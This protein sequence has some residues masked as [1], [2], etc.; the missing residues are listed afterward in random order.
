[1]GISRKRP[2]STPLLVGIG[3]SA[4]LLLGLIT[5]ELLL[6][7]FVLLQEPGPVHILRDLRLAVLHCLLAGYLPAAFLYLLRSA[8]ANLIRLKPLL[9]SSDDVLTI[10]LI[11]IAGCIGF[12]LLGA[13]VTVLTPYLSALSPWNPRI[14]PPEVVWH[15]VL[16][17]IIGWFAGCLSYAIVKVSIRISRTAD[18]LQSIDLLDLSPLAPFVRQGVRNVL[19]IVGAMSILS[20]FLMESGMLLTV[21]IVEGIVIPIAVIGLILPVRG[22]HRRIHDA[23]QAELTWA[24]DGIHE[25]QMRLKDSSAGTVSSQMADLITYYQFI[26]EVPEW[27]FRIS[28]F[29]RFVLYLLIPL[30]SWGGGLL[31][32]L[33]LKRLLV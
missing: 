7:R 17:P 3:L 6:G 11:S 8:K 26:E 1:M 10:P 4:V 27:P 33:L 24:L 25:A 13:A 18:L 21:M 28:T 15:R 29:V 20:F 32:E 9:A 5:S 14:W 31:V 12:G 16:G 19:L 22:V 30:A 2:G 23:K